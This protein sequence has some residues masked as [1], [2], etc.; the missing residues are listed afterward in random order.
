LQR[1]TGGHRL[2]EEVIA[3]LKSLIAGACLALCL[4][5]CATTG[6]TAKTTADAGKPTAGCVAQ[7]GT[8]MNVPSNACTGPGNVYS[9]QDLDNTG[10]TDTA[11]ALRVLDPALTVH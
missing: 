7:T 6:T 4:G 1:I 3:M 2:L 9:K 5:A 8:L 11:S 10:R